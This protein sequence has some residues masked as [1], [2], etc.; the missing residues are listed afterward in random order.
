MYGAPSRS[1]CSSC[2]SSRRLKSKPPQVARRCCGRPRAEAGALFIEVGTPAS[3]ARGRRHGPAGGRPGAG[4]FADGTPGPPR[5]VPARADPRQRA[6]LMATTWTRPRLAVR[7]RGRAAG[8]RHVRRDHDAQTCAGVDM[9]AGRELARRREARGA[10]AGPVQEARAMPPL[11]VEPKVVFGGPPA[12]PHRRG[13]RAS[14]FIG[15]H[16]AR[17]SPRASA[18]TGRGLR[19]SL[20]VP[21]SR[22]AP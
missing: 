16:S 18:R 6:L 19:R 3:C 13:L 9:H 20:G 11:K 21:R 12:H 15:Y 10:S 2:D 14:R 4:V 8:W 17:S 5:V 7:T 22:T 1:S